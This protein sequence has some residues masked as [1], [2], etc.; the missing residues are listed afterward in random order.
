MNN[1]L[2]LLF[3]AALLPQP[4]YAEITAKYSGGSVIIGTAAA[5]TCNGAIEGA[6]RYNTTADIH[7]YCNGSVWKQWIAITADGPPSTPTDEPGYFVLTSAA[8]N[9]NLGGDAG[10]DA[11][12]LS[13]L[14]ANDWLGKADAV[15]RGLLNSV[16]VRAFIC[17]NSCRRGVTGITYKFAV[18]GE[19][20]K[21]GA[22]FVSDSNGDG[23]NNSQNWSGTNYFDGYKEYWAGYAGTSELVSDD[24]GVH[25]SSWYC[26][27]WTN[28]TSGQ[29]G[30]GGL[31]D[32]TTKGRWQ[33]IRPT[34]DL[35]KRLVCWVHP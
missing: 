23:P 15:S 32:S 17:P 21:G 34:C 22:S 33:G 9:G 4:A 24:G 20:T 27:T 14:T 18:S 16:N 13:D 29:T 31:S 3:L 11:K 5:D 1:I 35:E 25:G 8:W 26:D 10:A 30:G 28:G 6:I 19:N 7:E 12:C 2:K